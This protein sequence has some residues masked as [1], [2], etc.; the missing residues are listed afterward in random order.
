MEGWRGAVSM[1]GQE[2]GGGVTLYLEREKR[3]IERVARDLTRL[4]ADAEKKKRGKGRGREHCHRVGDAGAPTYIAGRKREGGRERER[5]REK[6]RGK[7]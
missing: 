6:E 4:D 1:R 5:E 3:A 7:K 2:R